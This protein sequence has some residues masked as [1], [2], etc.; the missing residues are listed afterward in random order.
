MSPKPIALCVFALALVATS[1]AVA[2]EVV[3]L[4]DPSGDDDGPGKYVYPTDDA[5]DKGAFDLRKLTVSVD[6]EDVE[7]RVR[8]GTKIKD[9]WRSKEWQGNGFSVQM[10]LVFLDTDGKPGSGH[11][12]T[13]P[14]INVEFAA[15]N[16]WDKV[17]LLSPQPPKRIRSEIEQKAKAFEGA[18]VIPKKTKARGKELIATVDVSALG[19]KPTTAWGY[20]VLV[21][22]NEGYPAPTDFLTRKV[23]EYEGPH[24]FGGG[25][26]YDCDPHVLDMLAAPAKGG[27]GEKATQHQLLGGYTCNPD[28]SGKRAVLPMIFPA[29][30]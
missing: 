1:P 24:R 30:R 4:E 27:D 5:Y 13:L 22:S 3:V 17:V 14:G 26:D 15:A 12:K 7:L 25:T 20:Q 23:N 21:Q 19:G 2:E 16:A 28:G 6:G 18:I 11:T 8:L 10:V 29:K 9:P